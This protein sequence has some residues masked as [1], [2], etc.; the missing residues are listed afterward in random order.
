MRKKNFYTLVFVLIFVFTNGY[1]QHI[2]KIWR[3]NDFKTFFQIGKTSTCLN[4]ELNLSNNYHFGY[5]RKFGYTE[6]REPVTIG[7]KYYE[8]FNQYYK[9]IRIENT[10]VSIRYKDNFLDVIYGKYYNCDNI[11]TSYSITQK[12]AIAIAEFF[13]KCE[14]DTNDV[15][16][17]VE[18]VICANS[19]NLK[20]TLLHAAYK[21]YTYDN[22]IISG[23]TG[24]ILDV[25]KLAIDVAG[26]ADTRYSGNRSISTR[27]VGQVYALQDTT[28]GNGIETFDIHHHYSNNL[29]HASIS[30]FDTNAT[31]IT[32][33]DNL[34][35]A[36][37][38]HNNAK[39]D[40]ALDCHWAMMQS[41]DY[42]KVKHG[43]NSFDNQNTKIK[44]YVH[45]GTDYANASW[46]GNKQLFVFGDGSNLANKDIFT[47]LDIV[48]H[49]FGHAVCQHTANLK[50]R[51]EA[52][53]INESLSDIWGACIEQWA[54]TNK[55]TWLIGEDLGSPLRSMS[56]P[57]S[58]YFPALYRG[59]YWRDTATSND[60]GGV[61]TN[62]TVMDL[63]FHLL[64]MGGS[65]TNELG[66]TYSIVG[67]GI[68]N[69]ADIVYATETNPMINEDINFIDMRYF[70]IEAAKDLYGINSQ[71]AKSVADAWYAVGVYSDLF[72]PDDNFDYGNE[73]SSA[74]PMWNSP[75]IWI[76]DLSGNLIN[77]RGGEL[78]N[79]CV[80]I[81]NNKRIASSGRE[82][83]YINWAKAG[84][85]LPWKRNWLGNESFQCGTPKGGWITSPSGINLEPIK[86]DWGDTIIK[87]QWLVPIAENYSN[88][89]EFNNDDELWHFCITARVHDDLP[90]NGENSNDLDMGI[91]TI[92]NNN[93]A[94]KNISILQQQEYKAVVS[95]SN[96]FNSTQRYKIVLKKTNDLDITD[97]AEV[98]L[99]L[100]EGL[101]LTINSSEN[102]VNGAFWVNDNTLQL[103]NDNN[104]TLL[105]DLP[106]NSDFTIKTTLHFFSDI[107]PIENNID[108]DII[109]Y[110]ET[111][112]ILGGEHYQCIRTNGRFFISNAG[113]DTTILLNTTATLH[114]TQI[115]EDATYRWYDKQRNFLY[116]GVNYSPTPTQTTEYILEVTAESDGYRD[117]DTV[118][119]NVAPGCIHSI[120]PNP[121]SDNWI[122][123]SYE[124]ATT[125]TT[126]QLFIYNTGSTTLVGN[127]D[128][129]NI[130][131]VS[132]LDIEVTNY[133][134]G[135]YT[136]VL[137]CDNTVCHSKVLIR[138]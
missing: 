64:S 129:S 97:Y 115:N 125:I 89:T 42:F 60:N 18:K 31:I 98:Y 67:I 28:R 135:S 2:K 33:S 15:Y 62:C 83:L 101:L 68:N 10:S 130:G 23:K 27:K 78:C 32:D 36:S 99:S 57:N 25:E 79:V 61:H 133:P 73:P 110:D 106:P 90:I 49:E 94:W 65:G 19:S 121:V 111:E 95:I 122:T 128:L 45:Y 124:Y 37:E 107:I 69:A 136:V 50:N 1:A 14:I 43:R 85:Y 47:S 63:W 12:Q 120:T 137:V 59:L 96:P 103:S 9:G 93:V 8:V 58:M 11:D 38:Y 112:N 13:L 80:K 92:N 108:F 17:Y 72:I 105:L 117:L 40:G 87:V 84:V 4:E 24:E 77:P 138:Q 22:I 131:N 44:N 66:D 56:N 21:I 46:V 53:A 100:D 39:D 75:S 29:G 3:D 41:Y 126:A 88:C 71:E 20:D 113:N 51:G 70:T 5:A 34:W 116:E 119:V 127:Y 81:F 35:T 7:N 114:A 118:K 48:A 104:A 54:T 52:G 16:F 76:E 26:S 91:F 6:Y 86:P 109:L 102:A 134:T 132:S 123:V 55:Q 82:K 30:F 74:N